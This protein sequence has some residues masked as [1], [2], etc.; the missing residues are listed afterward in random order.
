MS[1]L[2]ERE[3]PG[4]LVITGDERAARA[5]LRRQ[6]GKLELQLGRL[7]AEA[8]PRLQLNTSVE[9]A[10]AT[11]RALDLGELERVRD[12]LATR[13]SEARGDLARKDELETTNK[14]LLEDMLARPEDHKWLRISRDSLG[15]PGCGHWHS[16]PRFGLLGMLMGWWRVKISS[17][18]PL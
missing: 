9:P 3:K 6:I 14:E 2:L 18:C 12:G 16:R 15:E 8:F 5:E 1:V 7:A 13:V 17:G 10:A 4:P 11:P